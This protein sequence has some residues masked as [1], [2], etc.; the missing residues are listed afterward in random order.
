MLMREGLLK[1][2]FNVKTGKWYWDRPKEG[3]PSNMT[4]YRLVNEPCEICGERFFTVYHNIGTT[5]SHSCATTKRNYI[6][7]CTEE[8]KKN[9]GKANAGKKRTQDQKDAM[10]YR[11][12]NLKVSMGEYNPMFDPEI[13]EK[14]RQS[15]I[16]NGSYV[17]EKNP[18]WK[19]GIIDQGYPWYFNKKLKEVIKERDGYK[20]Q[21]PICSSNDDR[22]HVHHIDYDRYNCEEPNLITLCRQCNLKANSRRD[23]HTKFY[24]YIMEN[25]GLK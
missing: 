23:F 22:L 12:Q 25:R 1:L 5:C 4:T 16:R 10:K 17:G 13:V 8:A 9:I 19:G 14:R 6:H 7:G 20:C 18:R 11:T 24:N 21:N 3:L 15:V 2:R